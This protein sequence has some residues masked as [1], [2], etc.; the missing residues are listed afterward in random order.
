MY[1]QFAR[2]YDEF[3]TNVDYARRARYFDSL[4]AQFGCGKGI[5]LDLACGT[6]SL[7]FAME[8]LGYDVIGADNSAEM[9]DTAMEK[10]IEKNSAV[11]FLNQD[12]EALDLFGTVTSTICAL[13]SLNHLENIETVQQ[14][15]EKVSLFT[16]PGGVFIFDVNTLYKHTELLG[17]QAFVFESEDCFLTWQN[18]LCEDNS[19]NMYLDFFVPQGESYRRESEFI[20]EYYYSDERLQSAAQNAGFLLCGVFDDLSMQQPQET[21]ERKIF[22]FKKKG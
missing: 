3:T 21:G 8:A 7:S 17:N 9:L 10:K 2:Y 16:E 13:D 12:M 1:Q 18:E 5:L 6:G 11:M 14:V 22:V 15:F 20:K 19:V 4:I